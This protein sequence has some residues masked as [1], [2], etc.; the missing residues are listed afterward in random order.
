MERKAHI[1]HEAQGGTISF[2]PHGT[3]WF[4]TYDCLICVGVG[5]KLE[6][7][8]RHSDNRFSKQVYFRINEQTAFLAH[9]ATKSQKTPCLFVTDAQGRRIKERVLQRLQIHARE[10]GWTTAQV[11]SDSL[12]LVCPRPCNQYGFIP[13]P[14]QWI[15]AAVKEF[16]SIPQDSKIET[17]HAGFLKDPRQGVPL[18]V[19]DRGLPA[20]GRYPSE[21]NRFDIVVDTHTTEEWRFAMTLDD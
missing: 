19:P 10:N 16:L 1:F 8:R 9:I 4:G 17:T 14:G 20:M 7:G 2:D 18:L 6:L 3:D 15:I 11:H 5:L 13:G 21:F 12:I